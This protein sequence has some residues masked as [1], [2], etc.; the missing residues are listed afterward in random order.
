MA[1]YIDLKE[2]AKELR[3]ILQKYNGIPSQKEDK[4][5]HQNI[6]YYVKTYP[7]EPEIK[8]LI[9]EF[10]LLETKKYFKD[11]ESH[12]NKIKEILE[13]R[14]AMPHSSQ[15][16]TLYG[17]VKDFFKKYK[18]VPD[19]EKLKYQYAGPS[20]FP[21]QDTAYGKC[22][23]TDWKAYASGKWKNWKSDVAFEYVVYVWKRYG[24]LP[25]ENTKP[26]QEVRHKIH[27]YCRYNGNRSRKEEIES[28]FAFS[29]LM[30]EFGCEDPYFCG[31]YH[32]PELDTE[33]VQERIRQ[34]LIENGACAVRYIAQ[35]ALTNGVL[36]VEYIYYY[37]YLHAYYDSEFSPTM[38]LGRIYVKEED[39][40]CGQG[41]LYVNYR[42]Y[43]KC[44]INKIRLNA[45]ANFRDWVEHPPVTIEEWQAYGQCCF[46]LPDTDRNRWDEVAEKLPLLNWNETTIQHAFNS[47]IPYYYFINGYKYDDFFMYLIENGYEIKKSR[48]FAGYKDFAKHPGIEAFLK[49]KNIIIEE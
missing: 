41:I 33:E 36:P 3:I 48:Y 1:G 28:L 23:T 8:S 9:D 24:I 32:C 5:A 12:F 4:A 37:Y 31:F 34:L 13:E 21:L 26:M 16:K 11:Y 10:G 17:F 2:K 27:Y 39:Y 30:E 42:D 29:K 38:P 47:S 7:D 15:E 45:Q 19:V 14:K 40:D 20:C 43:S 46:F 18:D 6:K 44:D 35:K 25:A 49:E 22:P